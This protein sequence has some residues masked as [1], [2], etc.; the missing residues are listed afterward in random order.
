MN[1]DGTDKY[2]EWSLERNEEG[3]NGPDWGIK[4]RSRLKELVFRINDWLCTWRGTRELEACWHDI[5][6]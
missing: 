1:W 5:N 6:K 2:L 3:T 4:L